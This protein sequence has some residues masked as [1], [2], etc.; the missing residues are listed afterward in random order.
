M[1]VLNKDEAGRLIPIFERDSKELA[2]KL[3]RRNSILTLLCLNDALDSVGQKVLRPLILPSTRHPETTRQEQFAVH[4]QITEQLVLIYEAIEIALEHSHLHD[5]PFKELPRIRVGIGEPSADTLIEMMRKKG[6]IGAD[7][8]IFA[9]EP[10]L[11][12]TVRVG[13]VIVVDWRGDPLVKSS[14]SDVF[15]LTLA[16]RRTHAARTAVSL[17]LPLTLVDDQPVPM[18]NFPKELTL[19]KMA[20]LRNRTARGVLNSDHS[21]SGW[22]SDARQASIDGMQTIDLGIDSKE[23]WN[24]LLRELRETAKAFCLFTGFEESFAS[25]HGYSVSQLSTAIESLMSMTRK[26]TEHTVYVGDKFKLANEL[27]S[28]T[29]LSNSVINK[30]IASLTWR[31]GMS[32]VHAPIVTNGAQRYFSMTGVIGAID[33]QLE[34]HFSD[35]RYSDQ[36]GKK[37]EEKCREILCSQGF[38]VYPKS[39][40]LPVK[41]L[42][43]EVS[44]RIWNRIKTGTDIDV[45][46]RK[47]EY[48]YLFECKERKW[49]KGDE[50]RLTN[51]LSKTQTDLKYR[52]VWIRNNL[53]A[54]KAMVGQDWAEKLVSGGPEFGIIP[55]LVSNH[56]IGNLAEPYVPLV[57][58]FELQRFNEVTSKRVQGERFAYLSDAEGS[59]SQKVV[60]L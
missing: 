21:V 58:I 48:L 2:A 17:N 52:G 20:E 7:D 19:E 27:K 32:Y 41:Y 45:L 11:A 60:I 43:D 16:L 50:K 46:A 24:A 3:D 56:A 59:I 8:L 44:M 36:L 53:D 5:R 35:P 26:T 49:S 34:S 55:L 31:S 4:D 42:P 15:R 14:V 6:V 23:N 30:V 37:F 28:S 39:L 18:V 57:T 12:P 1:R 9:A 33:L 54:F 40:E 25:T 10:E 51:L 22:A 29:G 47:K 38:T 13:F